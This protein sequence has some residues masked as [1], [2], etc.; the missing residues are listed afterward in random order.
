MTAP[1]SMAAPG[2]IASFV[3]SVLLVGA[4][5]FVLN[6]HGFH[7]DTMRRWHAAM[8]LLESVPEWK[9]R[10]LRIHVGPSR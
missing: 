2:T 4:A 9:K 5:T 1:P 10:E 8:L 6:A 7:P 3:E